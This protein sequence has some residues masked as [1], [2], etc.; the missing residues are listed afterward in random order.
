M[1]DLTGK[2][3]DQTYD[4]LIKTNNEQPIDGT[5]RGLQDG[6]GNNLPVQVSTS[7]INFTGVVTGDNNTTYD[8]NTTQDGPNVVLE[9]QP[10][11]GGSID[12]NL[13]PGSGITLN[14]ASNR[15]IEIAATGGGGGATYTMNVAQNGLNVDLQLLE[16]GIV[17]DTVTLQAGGNVQLNQQGQ[18]VVFSSTNTNTTYQYGS[19]QNGSDVD[20]RL[21]PSLGAPD[22]VKLVAGTN[23]T[24]TDNGSSEVTIDAAGGGGATLYGSKYQNNIMNSNMGGYPANTWGRIIQPV[25]GRP[26]MSQAIDQNDDSV[27]FVRAYIEPGQVINTLTVPLFAGGTTDLEVFFYTA[28]PATA[29]PYELIY[30]ETF[31][32]TDPN[33]VFFDCNLSS[34]QTVLDENWAWVGL[35]TSNNRKLAQISG[36]QA[37]WTFASWGG[38]GGSIQGHIPLNTYYFSGPVPTTINEPFSWSGRDELTISYFK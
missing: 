11:T 5:L 2:R 14:T 28:G 23:I 12:V 36:D 24:L 18:A 22:Q 33:D 19:G 17:T 25:V 38:W 3:I 32:V 27:L 31:N 34:P 13:I 20:L 26:F 7:T 37:I 10:D 16:D 1:G 8:L 21:T 30:S 29:Q 35:R 4:G 6:V 9:L 15:N